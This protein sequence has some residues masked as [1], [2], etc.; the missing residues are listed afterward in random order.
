MAKTTINTADQRNAT[1]NA[2]T[3]EQVLE[4][5]ADGITSRANTSSSTRSADGVSA[6]NAPV[7]RVPTERVPVESATPPRRKGFNWIP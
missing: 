1:T 2:A 3:D 4:R 7:E 5:P 6:Q